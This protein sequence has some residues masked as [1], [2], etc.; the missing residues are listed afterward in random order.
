MAAEDKK[1]A[2]FNPL[3]GLEDRYTA[4]ILVIFFVIMMIPIIYLGK[5]NFMKADDFSY[6]DDAHIAYVQTGSV[7]EGLKGALVSVRDN[8]YSWQGTFSSI[9]LMSSYPSVFNYRFY[10]L[11]PAI[12]V[13]M[14]TVSCFVLSFTLIGKVL[15]CPRKSVAVS[16]GALLALLMIERLYTVP[17]ALYWYNAAVHYIFAECIFFLTGAIY[18]NIC[19]TDKKPVK[20][21]LTVLS[22]LFAIEIG[23]SNYST[24]VTAPVTLLTLIVILF[25]AKKKKALLLLPSF[26]VLLICVTINVRAPG[27]SVRGAF[28]G[29]ESAFMSILL[30]FKSVFEFSLKW[31]DV[32]TVAML[33]LLAP[34]LLKTVKNTEYKFKFPLLVFAYSI[35]IVATGFT[36]S[37]Y[38]MGTEGISRTQNVIKMMWQ[39]LLVVNEGYFI[40]WLYKKIN[41]SKKSENGE[42]KA[43]PLVFLLPALLVFVLQPALLKNLGTIP[44]YTA[45]EYV[46]GGFAQAYWVESMERKEILENP[47]IKNAVIKEHTSKPFY[48]FVSDITDDP[49]YWE[50]KAMASYY[51]KDSVVLEYIEE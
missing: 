5:Y 8:Y 15:K 49:D 38:A 45:Y 47:E 50:N 34:I 26:A 9:F 25:F 19:L 46:K 20:V 33:V 29:G 36:S 3:F 7:I 23:G 22:I 11:V 30:S 14:I 27:N 17:G 48:L 13:S 24:V 44:T 6:C 21:L 51:Q 39:L 2:K 43:A 4:I 35:C 16:V 41:I 37:Y 40:G 10:K 12:M 42:K 31:I 1:S 32:Y 28:Y 18:I